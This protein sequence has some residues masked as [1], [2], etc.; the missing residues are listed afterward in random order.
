MSRSRSQRVGAA[1][2]LG[3]CVLV[4]ACQS[5]QVEPPPP[6]TPERMEYITQFKT[7]DKAGK[8]QISLD[9]ANAYYSARF[10][11]LDRNRDGFLDAGEL[12]AFVPVMGATTGSALLV[13]LDRNADNKV[14]RQEFL[15][16]S[17]W[18]FQLARTPTAMSLEEAEKGVSVSATPPKPPTLFGN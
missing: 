9:E 1:A 11:E 18:L 12:Q 2:L 16:V 3:S 14:S 8:G 5:A 10:N 4:A 7:I 17:N 6:P 15:T 13:K